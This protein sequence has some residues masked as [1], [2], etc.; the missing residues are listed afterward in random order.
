MRRRAFLWSAAVVTVAAGAGGAV[1]WVGDRN[2][3]VATASG[4]P[5]T[6]TARVVRTD[7]ATSE[8][9]YGELGFAGRVIVAGAT[10][11]HSYTWLP[12]PGA[13]VT[14]P[15]HRIGSSNARCRTIPDVGSA[16]S[17]SSKR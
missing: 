15:A 8:P 5:S 13:V 2:Q 16:S 4:T 6:G 10:G 17:R 3:P 12:A 14:W 1:V 7:L 11:G 9:M